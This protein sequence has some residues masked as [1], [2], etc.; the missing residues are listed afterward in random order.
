[1]TETNYCR[2]C[3][4]ELSIRAEVCP[5]CGVRQ[6]MDITQN[7]NAGIAAVLSFLFCGLGQIYNGEIG[8]GA[9]LIILQIINGIILFVGI[10]AMFAGIPPIGF[11]TYPIVW[12]YGVWDAYTT[13]NKINEKEVI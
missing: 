10:F 8:K 13:A 1:M 9:L 6:K 7:K 4:K 2:G 5:E 12:I 3:G 11:I